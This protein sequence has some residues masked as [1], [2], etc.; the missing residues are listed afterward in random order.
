MFI[1]AF[2]F[3]LP[4]DRDRKGVNDGFPFVQ[5]TV[6]SNEQAAPAKEWTIF[7]PD[8]DDTGIASTSKIVEPVP[9]EATKGTQVRL[10][11]GKDILDAV[12]VALAGE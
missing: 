12:I 8:S 3:K 2:D 10:R 5:K 1:S 11:W 9:T 6:G 4:I 7:F